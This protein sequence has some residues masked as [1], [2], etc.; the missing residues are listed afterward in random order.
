MFGDFAYS[1]LKVMVCESCQL[2][3]KNVTQVYE[4]SFGQQNM[5]HVRAVS[6]VHRGSI[7]MG[8]THT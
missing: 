2:L 6:H 4:A 7:S 5:A 8:S 1:L 3:I